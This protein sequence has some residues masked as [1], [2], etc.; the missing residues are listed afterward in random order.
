MLGIGPAELLI[1]GLVG[2]LLFGS[3]LPSIARSIGEAIPAFKAGLA[4]V[5]EEAKEV[6]VAI[7]RATK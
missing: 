3:K 2:F 5:D 4:G 1:V 6:S 7:K